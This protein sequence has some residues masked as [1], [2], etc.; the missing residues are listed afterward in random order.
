MNATNGNG[1]PRAL[2]QALKLHAAGFWPV[3]IRPGQKR[4][5]SKDWGARRQT[6]DDLHAAFK[7]YPDAGI[8]I[9]LGP[10][11]GPGGTWLIDLEGDG[12]AAAES[13]A[14]LLGGETPDT[15]SWTSTRGN[16][17]LFTADGTRLLEVLGRAGAKPMGAAQSGAYHLDELPGLELRVGGTKPDG[18]VKQ[19]QSVAPPTPGTDGRPRAWTRQPRGGLAPL[20][21]AAYARLEIIAEGRRLNAETEASKPIPARI[22]P[23]ATTPP[24]S[25][26]RPRAEDRAARYLET[27]EPAISGSGGHAKTFA[28]ACRVG[29]GFDLAPDVA[30]E[31]IERHYNPRC[32]PPWS[33]AEL[34]HK[35]EDAYKVETDRGW[36]LRVPPNGNGNGN[37]N[38]RPPAPTPPATDAPDRRPEIAVTVERHIVAGQALHALDSD[39][40]LY[41]RG[42]TLGTAHIESQDV[43]ELP[44]GVSLERARGSTRFL[45]LSDANLGLRLTAAA[46][47][48]Q[49]KADKNGEPIARDC[50]PPDWLIK[51]INS[52]GRWPRIRPLETICSTPYVRADGSLPAPGYDGSTGALYSPQGPIDEPPDRPTAADAREAA[53]LL[54]ALVHQFPFATGFDFAAWL[55]GLLTAIQR[56]TIAGAVPGVAVNGNRAGVGKGLLI[57]LVGS[58]AWGHPIP[59]RSYPIDPIEAAKVKL[60]IALSGIGAV[61]FDNLLEGGFY[62]GGELDSALTSTEVSGRILGQSRES[63]PVP[64]RPCW[65]LSGNNISPAT[66]SYRR[67]LVV[68]LAT[69]L[70]SPHERTDLQQTDLRAWAIE[71]RR[72]PLRHALTILRAHALAGRPTDGWGPL[73]SYE[74]WDPIVRGAVWFA[75]GNDCLTT[76]RQAAQEMPG[77]A[78][79]LALLEG[80]GELPGGT[81]NGLTVEEA[82]SLVESQPGMF[83]MLHSAFQRM[84]KEGKS[85]T[86]RQI[87]N[88][89]RAMHGQNVGGHKFQKTGERAHAAIWRVVKA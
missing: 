20:P 81:D 39:P 8:G 68:N 4:P 79:K 17:T 28:A 1:S 11:R 32:E 44:H 56:P 37:G 85:P 46:R 12:P 14:T 23:T 89:I 19:L 78:D 58:I 87:G 51:A 41:R 36:L 52:A 80:W 88:K 72:E 29:P 48:Y 47:F 82:M 42:D 24:T 34:A 75:T 66:D 3:P 83:P 33:H 73:G 86:L 6:L 26:A 84:T 38:G 40:D 55:A 64:L 63:G 69:P 74:Q 10:G 62:G 16:H 67:W 71:H 5:I 2:A 25:P 70:E 54:F 53:G 30:L 27:I 57:D 43:A 15:P 13:L 77:R 31:L 61:H 60:S 65:W 7:T 35:V 18:T 9:A 21:E 22:Q 45:P 76:Q 49:V 59:T 50:H